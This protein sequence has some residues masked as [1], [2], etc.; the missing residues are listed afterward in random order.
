MLFCL[1]PGAFLIP[2]TIML[3]I[4]GI[5]LV[6]LELSFGQFA[7]EGVVTV[8]RASPFFQGLSFISKLNVSSRWPR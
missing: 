2:F 7:S 8:W 5:P 3:F 6:Y 4:S 1:V